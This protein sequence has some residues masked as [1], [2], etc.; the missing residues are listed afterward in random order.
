MPFDHI[1]GLC[2]GSL[3]VHHEPIFASRQAHAGVSLKELPARL[4]AVLLK[5]L[6]K[7]PADRFQSGFDLASA[8]DAAFAHPT[9]A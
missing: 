1:N 3:R 5:G 2:K 7:K 9:T 4:E 6:S 8:I